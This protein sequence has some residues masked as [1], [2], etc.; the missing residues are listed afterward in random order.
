MLTLFKGELSY[1]EFMRE[2]TY[3]EMMALRDA[4]I[5]QLLDEKERMEKDRK[6]AES[7]KLRDKLLMIDNRLS[8]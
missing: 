7:K 6:D 4:R 1:H 5:K 2:M 3:N 8:Q